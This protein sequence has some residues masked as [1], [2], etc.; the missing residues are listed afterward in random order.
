MVNLAAILSVNLGA[1][2]LFPIPAMDGGRLLFLMIEG[3]RRKPMDR[4][5]EGIVHFAG[6]VLLMSFMVFVAYQDVLRIFR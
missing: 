4:E 5:K 2:N 1:I 6:F 3:I